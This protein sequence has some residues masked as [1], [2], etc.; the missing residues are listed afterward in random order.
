MGFEKWSLTKLTSAGIR[1]RDLSLAE[2]NALTSSY[3]D[4]HLILYINV[5]IN[6]TIFNTDI[7]FYVII[8]E[9]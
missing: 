5:V 2:T 9:K 3:E 1:T 4:L 8:F 7:K 6:K